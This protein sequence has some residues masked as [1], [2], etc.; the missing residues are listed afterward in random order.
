[1]RL[2][3]AGERANGIFEDAFTARYGKRGAS[4]CL[5]GDQGQDWPA[6]AR[7]RTK[8]GADHHDLPPSRFS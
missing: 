8:T 6:N 5:T 7:R 3:R 4:A 1:M 2:S